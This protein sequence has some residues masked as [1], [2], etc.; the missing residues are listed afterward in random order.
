MVLPAS[1]KGVEAPASVTCTSKLGDMRVH[2]SRPDDCETN[3][4]FT[5]NTKP[6]LS[7]SC[8]SAAYPCARWAPLLQLIEAINEDFGDYVGL[9]SKLMGLE[10]AVVRMKQP[11]VDIQVRHGP[12]GISQTSTSAW[13]R[14]G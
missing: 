8:T 1:S 4:T 6:P 7:R 9:S 3:G 11:L 5:I 13:P 12:P 2:H 10:G 14:I